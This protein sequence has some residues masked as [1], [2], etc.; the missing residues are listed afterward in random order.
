MTPSP[1]LAVLTLGVL[2]AGPFPACAQQAERPK[3]TGSARAAT[4]VFSDTTSLGALGGVIEYRPLGW[5]RFDVAPTL[6]RATSGATTTSGLGDLPLALEAST[7]L[8]SPLKPELAAS[9]IATL[10]TGRSACGLGSGTASVG[11]ELGVGITPSQRVHLSADASRSFTGAITLSSLDQPQST[12]LD[13]DGDVDIAPRWTLSLSAG[14]DVGGTDSAGVAADREVGTGLSYALTGSL[15]L[16]V[17][18]THRVAGLEPRWGVAVSLGTVSTGLS[19]LNSL[20]PV[21]LQRQLF[22]GGGGSSGGI[23]HGRGRGSG[24]GGGG[25]PPP[26]G[27]SPC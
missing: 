20:S 23:G 9:L 12:W 21:A 24:G 4:V 27:T 17:D 11:M 2:L 16:T 13:V 19:A 3:W 10:P 8:A 26:T 1:A 7:K 15:G 18:V 22:V 5:L 25:T 14:G 6:V